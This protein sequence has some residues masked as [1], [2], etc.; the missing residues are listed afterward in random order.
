[1]CLTVSCINIFQSTRPR[2]ARRRNNTDFAFSVSF[3]STRPRGARLFPTYRYVFL[4]AFQSTRPRGARPSSPWRFRRA[5]HFNPRARVGRDHPYPCGSA[6]LSSFQSTRP[7][8]ARRGR[9]KEARTIQHFNPRARVGRDP[10]FLYPVHGGSD[11]NPRARVGRDHPYPCG[12]A[13]LSSFQSTR[14]RG[15]RLCAET[16][17]IFY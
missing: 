13:I 3:Q 2:G 16:I 15:A 10:T 5:K 1:M 12:S 4:H 6:I 17:F 9:E 14:P 11:F 7:R 8:G